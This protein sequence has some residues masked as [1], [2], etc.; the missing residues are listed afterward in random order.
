MKQNISA[1]VAA[2]LILLLISLFV[3]LSSGSST[4]PHQANW[5]SSWREASPLQLSRR[6]AAAVAFGDFLY[7]V[8]GINADEHYVTTVEYARINKDGG[9][10]PWKTTTTLN[11]GCFYNAVIAYGGYLY[12]IGGGTGERGQNNYPIASVERAAILAD[13]S[14]GPWQIENHLTTPRRGLK[15]VLHGNTIYAIGGYNGQFLKSV[16]RTTIETDGH[17]TAW[18]LEPKQSLIDR[19]I[20]AAAGHG[21]Q[22]YLLGG[23]MRDPRQTSYGDVESTRINADNSLQSWQVERHTLLVPRLVAEAFVINQYLYIA[24]G[25]NG[26]DRLTS[27]EV[28]HIQDDGQLSPW[29]YTTPLPAPHSAAAVATHNHRVYLIGGGGSDS[30]APL[31]QVH[32]AEQN[33]RG[34][35]GYQHRQ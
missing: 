8:G 20:H 21:D 35:L 22:L 31:G 13:G 7:V 12:A 1:V 18:Q 5:S 33:L 6:A 3:W 17:L 24:G 26:G 23:H 10:S 30:E 11:E 29:R 16:E 14:L 28:S 34:D 32:F 9:L 25:H 27:V 4:T 15:T 2:L 19:Y